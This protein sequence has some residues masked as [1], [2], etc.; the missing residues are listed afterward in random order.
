MNQPLSQG[1]QDFA[2]TTPD[3]GRKEEDE[4]EID[5]SL[6]PVATR[7]ALLLLAPLSLQTEPTTDRT[8]RKRAHFDPVRTLSRRTNGEHNNKRVVYLHFKFV[9]PAG[10]GST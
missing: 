3:Q 2:G 5:D 4:G 7:L 1:K 9:P 10:W 8:D 6:E